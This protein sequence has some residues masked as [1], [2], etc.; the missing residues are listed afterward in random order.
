MTSDGGASVCWWLQL[1]GW[2]NSCVI[3]SVLIVVVLMVLM[4]VQQFRADPSLV[5]IFMALSCR[6]LLGVR[7]SSGEIVVSDLWNL[8]RFSVPLDMFPFRM[9]KTWFLELS[10][11]FLK[12]FFLVD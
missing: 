4:V 6:Q 10:L 7:T 1:C 2:T 8:M 5:M 3:V 9:R 12:K 11:A